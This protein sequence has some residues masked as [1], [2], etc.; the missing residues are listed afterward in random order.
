MPEE[1]H[2]GSQAAGD[3]FLSSAPF[4]WGRFVVSCHLSHQGRATTGLLTRRK[5][6][7]DLAISMSS[8]TSIRPGSIIRGPTLP[9]AVEVLA[10]VP[11]G[12]ALKIIG[13]GLNTGL[14]Y[15]PV[16]TPEQ[17]ARLTV[18]A[19]HEPFDGDARLF[20]LGVEAHRLG[21][22]FEYDPFFSLS[23]ARVDPLPHQ[24]EA[25]Y[26]Y[27]LRLPR[28]RFLLADDPAQ[29]RRSWPACCSRS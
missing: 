28:I 16:L 8:V 9:E 3:P 29:A 17:L 15:D 23:I 7:P 26:D 21:L 22:A 5:R 11:L 18:S 10:V 27:F 19:E 24:L 1:G 13:R 6:A 2:A 14:T 20:R 25:V 12:D 4:S